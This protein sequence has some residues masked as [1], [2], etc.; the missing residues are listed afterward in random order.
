MS[1]E[2]CRALFAAM[3]HEDDG[4]FI[5]P[6]RAAHGT[7]TRGA[8]LATLDGFN[9]EPYMRTAGVMPPT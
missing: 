1:V 7:T 9:A 6:A 2:P 3:G 8:V 5:A 4:P